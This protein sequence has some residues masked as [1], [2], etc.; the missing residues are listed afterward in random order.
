MAPDVGPRGRR[1]GGEFERKDT[2]AENAGACIGPSLDL[3]A[4]Q[5]GV[6]LCGLGQRQF[7]RMAL[8][9]KNVTLPFEQRPFH[10]HGALERVVLCP[11]A[12][13]LL[14]DLL[15]LLSNPL[16]CLLV[17]A[18]S[19]HECPPLCPLLEGVQQ[20]AVVDVCDGVRPCG[21]FEPSSLLLVPPL[22][23]SSGA[24]AGELRGGR[25]RWR[26]L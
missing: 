20:N 22:P 3:A 24:V 13:S 1:F 19:L 16:L 7:K 15:L 10:R 23:L 4:R 6:A 2:V 25:R 17:N 9:K 12:R 21:V 18:V 5:L 26:A 14:Q 11:H 8:G